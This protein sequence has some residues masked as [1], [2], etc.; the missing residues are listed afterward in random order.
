MKLFERSLAARCNDGS[1][2]PGSVLFA[3]KKMRKNFGALRLPAAD[4]GAAIIIALYFAILA[5]LPL[6]LPEALFHQPFSEGGPF[7]KGAI[8]AWLFAAFLIVARIRPLGMRAWV[9]VFVFVIFAVRE[10]DWD[11]AFTAN[12]MLTMNYY[13][14]AVAPTGEKLIAGVAAILAISLLLYAGSVILRFLFRQGGWRSRSGFWLFF[15]VLIMLFTKFI[16]RM[17]AI[18]AVDY[19]MTLPHL[20][21]K[22]LYS[23]E[24]GLEMLAPLTWAWSIW[25]SQA[26][27]RY[28]S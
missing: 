1:S 17:P 7:E 22:F 21:K 27:N 19:G 16:D 3:D 10:A 25:V 28:L 9:F 18:L 24:E 15:T 6:V 2:V 4:S 12:G 14:H 26:E 11:K 23:Y 20:V 13:R 8:V 5:V